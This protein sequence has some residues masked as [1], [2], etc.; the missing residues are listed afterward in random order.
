MPGANCRIYGCSVSRRKRYKDI[1]IFSVPKMDDEFHN[2]W[3]A[4]FVAAVTKDRVV[5]ASLRKQIENK[6]IGVCELHFTPEQVIVR[7][8]YFFNLPFLLRCLLKKP[9]LC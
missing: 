6:S 5:D 9:L 4:K 1:S 7:K 3:R 2:N 8:Y